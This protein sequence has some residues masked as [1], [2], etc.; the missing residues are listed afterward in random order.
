MKEALIGIGGRVGSR[1]ATELLG[2]G[3]TGYLAH[4]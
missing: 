4:G 1:L 2:R 3:N